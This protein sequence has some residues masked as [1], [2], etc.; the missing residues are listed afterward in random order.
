MENIEKKKNSGVLIIIIVLTLLVVGLGGYIIYDKVFN[1]FDTEEKGNNDSEDINVKEKDDEDNKSVNNEEVT[2]FLK[3]LFEMNFEYYNTNDD[4][5]IFGAILCMMTRNQEYEKIGDENLFLSSKINY[6]A[7]SYFNRLNFNYTKTST[8]MA[9]RYDADKKGM[10]LGNFGVC[11]HG[12]E[13]NRTFELVEAKYLGDT[14]EVIANQKNVFQ[15]EYSDKNNTVKY[16]VIL[17]YD[18]SNY[19]IVS[20]NKI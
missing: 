7:S 16:K 1:E 12:L 6:Y 2:I 15:D 4:D 18:N 8:N 3:K 19:A 9:S 5:G 14:I 20:I 13:P 10:M 17:S 11:P